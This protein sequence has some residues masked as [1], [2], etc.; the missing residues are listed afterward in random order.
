[1]LLWLIVALLVV[2]VAL[3][4]GWLIGPLLVAIAGIVIPRFMRSTPASVTCIS[5]RRLFEADGR[6]LRPWAC[7]HCG[8]KNTNLRRHYRS[9]ATL[10]VL[11]LFWNLMVMFNMFRRDATGWPELLVAGFFF[12][13]FLVTT[14]V[15]LSTRTPWSST[16]AKVLL[17]F[18]FGL[19]FVAH[20]MPLLLQPAAP[21]SL[22]VALLL[23]AF[24]ALVFSYLM[25]LGR[26]AKQLCAAGPS[27]APVD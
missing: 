13:P 14:V 22:Y 6:S 7:P 24:Y 19:A 8:K 5:C 26:K 17:W 16:P 15:I 1:M 21:G 3:G 18:V 9:L 12:L 4:P 11:G 27:A 20:V 2:V 23:A 25:W 10:L